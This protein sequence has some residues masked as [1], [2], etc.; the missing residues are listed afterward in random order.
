MFRFLLREPLSVFVLVGTLLFGAYAWLDDRATPPITLTSETRTA[1]IDDFELLTGR[2]ATSEEVHRL[3]QEYIAEELLFRDAV[4]QGLHLGSGDIRA[5]LVAEM[6][7][8]ITGLLPDPDDEALV[9]YYAEHIEQYYSE[10][11]IS[12]RHVYFGALPEDAPALLVRLRAGEDI[13]GNAFPQGSE[14]PAYGES[15][16]RG[17]FG[18]PFLDEL[19]S[20]PLDRWHGPVASTRGWHF[21]LPSE[22][23][24]AHRLSFDQVRG[25]VEQDYLR[26]LIQQAVDARVAELAAM[27]EVRIE[28]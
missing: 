4:T 10:P 19:G 11:A 28:R 13:I 26:N 20:I 14:F 21:V 15:M 17:L 9:N 16:L 3:E 5:E 18:Q 25:Q 24:P 2:A 23:L 12:F 7:L 6:R 1:L 22:R 8:A 27:Y